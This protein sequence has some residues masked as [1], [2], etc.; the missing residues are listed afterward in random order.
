MDKDTIGS[1][2][3]EGIVKISCKELIHQQKVEDWIGLTTETGEK[4]KGFLRI[5]IQ[6]I[7]SKL[8]LYDDMYKKSMD[9][10]RKVNSDI[11]EIDRYLEIIEKPYG[12]IL[13]GEIIN[14]SESKLL[15]KGE[16]AIHYLS[17]SRN[18]LATSKIAKDES[19]AHRLEQMF[20]GT[21]SK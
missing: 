17:G 11:E 6:L 19:M 21:L 15:E 1:D 12:I 20:R 7:W 4:E 13:Y 10:A 14:L 8:Q 3:L 9:Q 18:Y 16:E 5:R 2:D